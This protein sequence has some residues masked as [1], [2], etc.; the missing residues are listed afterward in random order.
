MSTENIQRCILG[1][2]MMW[3]NLIFFVFLDGS[4]AHRGG[5]TS[6]GLLEMKGT[7]GGEGWR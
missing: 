1:K 5:I 4:T 7:C 6:L 3:R 2:H